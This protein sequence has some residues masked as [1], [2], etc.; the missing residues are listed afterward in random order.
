MRIILFLVTFSVFSCVGVTTNDLKREL[1]DNK[2]A[3][4]TVAKRFLDQEQIQRISIYPTYDKALCQTINKYSSCPS[5]GNRWKSR[6]DSLKVDVY[7]NSIDE[8]L[9][10]NY[11]SRQDYDF[12]SS[13]LLE[14][15]LGQISKV[16]DCDYC[17]EFEY[18]LNGLRYTT[19]RSHLFQ[20]DDE[21]LEV[22]HI[23]DYWFVYSR[24]SN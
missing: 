14:H 3:F 12:Y 11:I 16:I 13:F 10:K 17:V 1:A 9:R 2:P 8:V 5:D 7:L 19:S 6:D 4:E 23:S 15:D 18:K 24:D 22:E 20:K 21:Y